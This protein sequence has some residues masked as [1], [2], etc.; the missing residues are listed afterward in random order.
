MSVERGRC[1]LDRAYRVGSIDPRLGGSFVEH[2][3]RG[4]YGG[5]F[6]PD[7]EQADEAGFRR[8]VIGLVRELG[9]PIVRYPGGNFVSGYRWED[10]IG[11][12]PLRPRRL[13]LA[14]RTIESN[15]FGTDEALSWCE[16]VGAEAM[17]AVNLGTR[18]AGA[19][20]ELVE[21]VNHPGT[22]AWSDRRRANGH[23]NPY[24][25]R[26]W[27][28]G[29]EMDGPW[30]LGHRPAADYGRDAL[31]AARAMRAVD[32]AIELVVCGSSHA[33]MPTH[34]T[35][36]AT[37]LD[38]CYEDV[39]YVSLHAYYGRPQHS[40]EAFLASALDMD[41]FIETVA[42]TCDY[43]RARRRS[44]R[45]LGLALDEWN[46]WHRDAEPEIAPWQEAPP[47]L[48]NR[49]DGEDAVV[50]G[51]LVN[52]LIRHADRVR[53]ACLAQLVN[54]IA[55]I[56]AERGRPAWRQSIYWPFRD[57]IQCAEGD[58][59][60]VSVTSPT[61]EWEGLG[62]VPMLD[63]AATLAGDGEEVRVLLANRSP[64]SDVLTELDLRDFP[65]FELATH[66]CLRASA[67]PGVGLGWPPPA[68]VPVRGERSGRPEVL[69][70]R[71]SWNRLVVRRTS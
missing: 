31:S 42:A 20:A 8:D 64:V 13:D 50:V 71:L 59:L 32:P 3:G 24:G 46:V 17:M 14:W 7:D 33:G 53:V 41:R 60:A 6:D 62:S 45:R 38:I 34:P 4:V 9:V 27:C 26:L 67:G 30:Q 16:R 2:L 70:P 11:P 37:V 1:V 44:S 55:P 49:Y 21:Y 63:G 15:Q 51:T 10:G 68:E 19:A 12:P 69:V 65:G 5:V 36:E 66:H 56:V 23:P 39:D 57:L 35:W 48:E 43:V 47:Q 61:S 18:G 52:S 40:R 54:V 28:L 58:A 22:S 25:V 29:N